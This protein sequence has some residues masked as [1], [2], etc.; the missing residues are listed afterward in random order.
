MEPLPQP[1][2][3]FIAAARV[4]RIATVRPGGAP[5]VIPVCPAFDGEATLYVDV[6]T[7]GVSAAGVRSTPKV[8]AIV[9]EYEDDWS[10]LRAVILR[11]RAEPIAGEELDGAWDMIRAK[12]P[13]YGSVGWEPRFTLA[14]R[15]E[16]WTQWGLTGALS[17]DPD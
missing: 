5:H 1:V 6:A 7:G 9:D 17:Y 2:K 12:F 15:I 3:D 10:K 4:C 8:T 11:C 14:L 13:Q 16:G